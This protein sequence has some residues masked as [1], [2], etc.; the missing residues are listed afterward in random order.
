VSEAE[1]AARFIEKNGGTGI[2]VKAQVHAGGR[3]KGRFAESGL[4]GGVQIVDRAEQVSGLAS[5]ML[6]NRL[7]TKQSGAAGKPCNA[8]YLVQKV[9]IQRELYISI[10]VD[11]AAACP[12]VI[13]SPYGGMGIEE[14][15]PANI[16]AFPIDT[17]VGMDD[18]TVSKIVTSLKLT[19][20]QAAGAEKVV[21]GI[22]KCFIE[23]DAQ[24][25]EINPLA[26]TDD[27]TILVC[28]TKVN[29]DD[30]SLFR[31]QELRSWDDLSQK[32]PKEV[33]A[34]R[35]DL[36]YISLDGNIGCMVNG[37]GLAMATM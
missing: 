29:V 33:D 22:Y 11:R 9:S 18:K 20:R 28:D 2:V 32:D 16:F 6:G 7:V 19:P 25:I 3:G 31:H 37:A 35:F 23:N 12:V 15:D 10:T 30:N 13:C 27:N 26:T 8:L 4:Q 17:K 36:N 34:E 5:K 14:Q 24:L 21:R 1:D